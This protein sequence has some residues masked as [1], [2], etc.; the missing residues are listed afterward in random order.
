MTEQFFSIL[1]DRSTN[2]TQSRNV[3]RPIWSL[4]VRGIFGWVVGRMLLEDCAHRQIE[5]KGTR[6]ENKRETSGHRSPR[7]FFD[8]AILS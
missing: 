3:D 2:F 4:S 5:P 8:G 7:F 6:K 1:Y